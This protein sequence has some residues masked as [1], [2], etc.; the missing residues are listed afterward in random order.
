MRLQYDGLSPITGKNTLLIESD[1]VL[2][3]IKM[4]MESGYQTYTSTWKLDNEEAI[5]N[6]EENFPQC[7]VE[8]RVV[9][10]NGNVWYRTFLISPNV[11]LYPDE[12]DDGV[13]VWKVSTLTDFDPGEGVPYSV[14][15]S[16]GSILNRY[17][18]DKNAVV[19]NDDQFEDALFA[20]QSLI[21]KVKNEEEN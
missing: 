20:F 1:P 15:Q 14:P 4:C 6:I 17:L 16:D 18:D 13:F 9:D 10:D 21:Y 5:E 2:G 8:S 12:I 19:F 7:V 11:L 3:E